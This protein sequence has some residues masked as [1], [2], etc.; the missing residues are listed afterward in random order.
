MH[1]LPHAT[2]LEEATLRAQGYLALL[3]NPRH[4]RASLKGDAFSSMSLAQAL[5][6]QILLVIFKDM[7]KAHGTLEL[8]RTLTEI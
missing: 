7:C 6:Y 4:L 8:I 5:R 3:T 2:I 1:G